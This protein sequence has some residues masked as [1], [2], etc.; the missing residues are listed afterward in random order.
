MAVSLFEHGLAS[1]VCCAVR[2]DMDP[3]SG[4][5]PQFQVRAVDSE[6]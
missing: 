4:L 5:G 3:G 1:S 2:S 6:L